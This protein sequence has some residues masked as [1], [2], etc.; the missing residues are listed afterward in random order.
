MFFLCVYMCTK[1]LSGACGGQKKASDLLELE[2]QVVV[3]N[4]MGTETRTQVPYDSMYPQPLSLPSNGPFDF[5]VFIICLY[6][7]VKGGAYVSQSACRGQKTTC[8]N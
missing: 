3:S 6:E 4:H 1:C 2:L 8:S 7:Y 5:F